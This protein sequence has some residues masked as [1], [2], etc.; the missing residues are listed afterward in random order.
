MESLRLM[1]LRRLRHKSLV[2]RNLIVLKLDWPRGRSLSFENLH[3]P[4]EIFPP[5]CYVDAGF[6]SEAKRVGEAEEWE[7]KRPKEEPG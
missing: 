5:I 4:L 2:G 1:G 6:L 3:F 7:G